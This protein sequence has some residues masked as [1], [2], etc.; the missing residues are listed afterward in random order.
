M[1]PETHEATAVVPELPAAID[2]Y[3]PIDFNLRYDDFAAAI[4]TLDLPEQSL[5]WDQRLRH[6]RAAKRRQGRQAVKRRKAAKKRAQ[7]S[8]RNAA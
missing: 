2:Y 4:A 6:W 3:L 5:L 8:R 1:S 7:A